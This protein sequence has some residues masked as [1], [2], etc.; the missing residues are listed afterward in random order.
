MMHVQP[1]RVAVTDR[2]I[3][4]AVMSLAPQPTARGRWVVVHSS[5]LGALV[6]GY[7]YSSLSCARRHVA[8]RRGRGLWAEVRRYRAADW[9]LAPTVTVAGVL[10]QPGQRWR[11]P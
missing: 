7:R 2:A 10:R 1:T 11:L 9:L 5:A 6:F 3:K 4:N 8:I